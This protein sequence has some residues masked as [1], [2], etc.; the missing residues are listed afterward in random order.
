MSVPT[1]HAA[2]E[3][4]KRALSQPGA[5][6][7]LSAPPGTGK[8]T[9]MPLELLDCPWLDGQRIVL[10]EPRRVA[11]RAVARRMA[12][13]LG[14][15]V[16][17]RVGYRVRFDTRVS[18]R[19]RIEVVTEGLLVRRLQSDPEL[20]GVGLVVFDELHERHLDTDLALALTLDTAGSLRP[21]L[22]VL[23]MSATLDA[24]KVAAVLNTPHYFEVVG[25]AFPVATHYLG[26]EVPVRVAVARALREGSG[27]VL[28]FLPGAAEIRQAAEEIESL[29]SDDALVVCPLYAELGP[30]A[31][32]PALE[33]DPEGRRKVVLATNIAESSLTIPGVRAVVDTGR[34]RVPVFDPNASLT[35]LETVRI[36]RASADQ[37][38]GRAGRLAPGRCYRL[39]TQSDEGAR[40]AY[41]PPELLSADLAPLALQLLA[42]GARHPGDLA[43]LDPL[44]AGA[45]GEAWSL[46]RSLGA[47]DDQHRLTSRGRAMAQ[48]PV[49]P[50]LAAMI[51]GSED[52]ADH[53]LSCRLAALIEEGGPQRGLRSRQPVDLVESLELLYGADNGLVDRALVD[54]QRLERLRKV[55]AA[56]VGRV[57]QRTAP[58]LGATPRASESEPV[59]GEAVARA[60]LKAYPDRVARAR[61]GHG[62]FLMANGRAVRVPAEARLANAR[63]LVVVDAG[64]RA[65]GRSEARVRAAVETT[66]PIVESACGAAI[67]QTNDVV[68]DS[69]ERSVDASSVR[70]L[71]A[72]ELDRR[73]LSDVEEAL[74]VAAMLNGVREMGISALPWT[75]ALMQ[76]RYRVMLLRRERIGDTDWPAVDDAALRANL[77]QWLSPYLVGVRRATHLARLDLGPALGSLLVWPQPQL[78]NDHAPGRLRVPGGREVGLRYR[79]DAAPV[80]SVPLQ[81]MLGTPVSPTIADGRVPVVIEL[82]SPAGRP[83]QVTSDLAS[84]WA[85]GYRDVRKEMRGRYPKHAWPED[86]ANARPH[87]GPKRQR[88][89]S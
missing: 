16:G 51:A 7:L 52:A 43:W 78:L 36:S 10:L 59:D 72:I 65:D 81:E 74:V 82:L 76:W 18:P 89:R 35:R 19:T 5:R 13:L 61:G 33:A 3:P 31:E 48:I 67:R 39:W 20:A 88:R 40:P 23:A 28:V 44:P 32:Q 1:L 83:I 75:E 29:E 79:P 66:V 34:A 85:D 64:G 71:G 84:F 9:R 2:V 68:W 77:V 38:R 87:R 6:A 49:H 62:R 42:W 69:R 60:L 56:L 55:E 27:D 24:G 63:W 41:H 46:L 57:R 11:A 14:E 54:R 12:S 26:R 22:R 15:R 80:L 21:D 37:R 86:P 50:R 58:D 17:E 45:L 4:L 70:H 25:E 73:A 30:G 47:V 8:T 53:M